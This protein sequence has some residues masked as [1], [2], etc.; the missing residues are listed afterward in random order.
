MA[1]S[2]SITTKA[3][4][5]G[6]TQAGGEV[7]PLVKTDAHTKLWHKHD[8][9]HLI[10]DELHSLIVCM[11]VLDDTQ[12]NFESAAEKECALGFIGWQ[13]V[14]KSRELQRAFA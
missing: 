4:A 6:N 10:A 2:K 5:R 3:A 14:L 1:N 13:I 11:S 8:A 12:F 9:C 7:V